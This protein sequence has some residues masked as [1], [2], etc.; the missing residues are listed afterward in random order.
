MTTLIQE[1]RLRVFDHEVTQI[2][3]LVETMYGIK[4]KKGKT[5]S[6]CVANM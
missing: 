1:E 3:Q 5:W 2:M 4:Y 6:L